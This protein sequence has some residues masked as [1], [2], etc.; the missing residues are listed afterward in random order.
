M[1]GWLLP[2]LSVVSSL[3][4]CVIHPARHN[5]KEENLLTRIQAGNFM[6]SATW[7]R[8]QEKRDD[9]GSYR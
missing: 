9:P 2:L 4:S 8:Y 7:E 3:L 5:D 1:E 6:F